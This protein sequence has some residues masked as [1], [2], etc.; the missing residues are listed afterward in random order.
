MDLN[1]LFHRH[2]ISTMMSRAA[3]CDASRAA[4]HGLAHGY[5][6]RIADRQRHIGALA[7][8]EPA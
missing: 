4:H 5:A 8:F 7:P 6:R 2:Q 3:A 1:Y